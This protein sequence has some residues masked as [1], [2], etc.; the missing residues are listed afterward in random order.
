MR[1]RTDTVFCFNCWT[2]D[3]KG[4]LTTETNEEAGYITKGFKSWKKAP[5]CFEEHQQSKCHKITNVYHVVLPK[6]KDVAEL[7]KENL[8]AERAKERRY[9]LNVI[10]GLRYLERQGIALQGHKDEDN[11]TQL[12]VLLGANDENI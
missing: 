5:K 9:L 1:F 12:M 7:T 2:K 11:F 6:C 3:K 8:S 4:T 10:R